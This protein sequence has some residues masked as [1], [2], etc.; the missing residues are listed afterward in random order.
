MLYQFFFGRKTIIYVDDG[1]LDHFP[2]QGL[3]SALAHL[4]ARWTPPLVGVVKVNVVGVLW[5]TRLALELVILCVITH[6]DGLRVS[7][8]LKMVVMLSCQD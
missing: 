6:V 2:Q 5:I 8:T 7:L 4:I 1:L 3:H